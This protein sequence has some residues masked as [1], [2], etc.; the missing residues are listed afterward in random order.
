[1]AVGAGGAAGA[2]ARYLVYLSATHI[3]G[4]SF[5]YGTLIVNIFG[6]LLMGILIE[7]LAL[8]WNVSNE[9]RLFMVVGVLGAFTTFSTFPLDFAVLYERGRWELC[10]L[11]VSVS[12]V[13]S[14]GV[15]F[16]GMH[17][18]RGFLAPEL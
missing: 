10:T 17:A 5:P 2:I 18:T 12:V 14:I 13:C 7:T 3:F 11:Y 8:A 4:H 6:S 16:L 15:L 9:L 1:M